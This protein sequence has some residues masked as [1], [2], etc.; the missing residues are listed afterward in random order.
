[1][2]FLKRVMMEIL[3]SNIGR[4]TQGGAKKITTTLLNSPPPI[5]LSKNMTTHSKRRNKVSK[6]N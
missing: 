1:M 2:V 3:I 5:K 6:R 4:R